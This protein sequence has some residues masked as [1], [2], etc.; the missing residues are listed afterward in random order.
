MPHRNLEFSPLL[1]EPEPRWN[2][3]YFWMLLI[4]VALVPFVRCM[5]RCKGER[6]TI[7]RVSGQGIVRTRCCSSLPAMPANRKWNWLLCRTRM[8]GT[9]D[10]WKPNFASELFTHTAWN[11][12]SR[13]T[14]LTRLWFIDSTCQSSQQFIVLF[15]SHEYSTV[16]CST[17]QT[18]T[19]ILLESRHTGLSCAC[20]SPFCVHHAIVADCESIIHAPAYTYT[21]T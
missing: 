5:F 3:S 7:G 11:I 2:C 1:Y 8:L 16:M 13:L 9:T 19:H 10:T 21:A 17:K 18:K 15:L 14:I 6:A 20:P 4:L 12:M